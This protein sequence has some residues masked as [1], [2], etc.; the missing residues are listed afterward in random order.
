MVSEDLKRQ[1]IEWRHKFH[2]NPEAAFEEVQTAA[3]VAQVL[4]GIGLEVH[5]GIGGT[6]VVGVLK[7]GAGKRAVGLRA[8]MDCIK[9]SERGERPYMSQ[10]PGRMHACGHDGHTTTLLGAAA[11]LS[12][13]R[14]FDGTV[15]FIFQP[16][17][18]PGLG[19]QAMLEDGLLQR[20]PMDEVYGL[21]N[22]PDLPQGSVSIRPGTFMSSEDD[23][24]IRIHGVGGHASAPH[25][26]KDP[27]V[28]AAEIILA[29][30]S[31]VSRSVDPQESAVVSFTEI[32]TDGAMNAIPSN[33][34]LSGDVR[35]YLPKVRELV[36]DR[37]R[38]ICR[39]ICEMNDM[40]FEFEY[41]HAFVPLVNDEQCADHVLK[42]ARD[43]LPED[44]IL[45]NGP[46]GSGSEDFA[47]FLEKVPGCFFNIGGGR[48][49]GPAMDPPLHNP[50]FD[51]NDEILSLGARMF[52][53]IIRLRLPK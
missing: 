6:G 37:M 33:V 29:M 22:I 14:D 39:H 20:F 11:L 13:S 38:E 53:E 21:H 17:E 25:V 7:N 2:A 1:M 32:H 23:F 8:D 4:T 43:L 30:Q 12:Q 9:I 50:L 41:V 26:T 48:C 52:A 34:T 49:K 27:I 16:A 40:A 44:K 24:V 18:E 10:I 45:F 46:R 5:T 42:A 47:R 35:A 36:E 31:I 3:F 19:A 28:T 51:Y 15:Y